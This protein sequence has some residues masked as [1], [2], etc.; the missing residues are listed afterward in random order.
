MIFHLI[1]LTK[2]GEQ[3]NNKLD[4]SNLFYDVEACISSDVGCHRQQNQDNAI[5]IQPN[6]SERNSKGFLAIVADG[7][8]GHKAG[9]IA[10]RLA[11]DVITTNF[12][13]KKQNDPLGSLQ[14]AFAKANEVIYQRS[15]TNELLSGMGTTSTALL[16]KKGYAYF[17]HVGDSRLYRIHEGRLFLLTEDH[18]VVNQMLRNGLI[19]PTEAKNHPERNVVT[20]ALGTRPVVEI[21]VSRDPCPIKIGDFFILCTDGLYDLVSDDEIREI[22]LSVAP[23]LAC[24]TLID[25]AKAKGG[26]DNISV[27]ILAIRALDTS[28]R[29]VPITRPHA[30]QAE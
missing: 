6:G 28:M 7:M 27:G 24:Q 17:A 29:P 26:Y 4:G 18:T 25:L 20:R 5:F 21:A 16:L 13:M 12:F 23:H 14:K 10:S 19:N 11:I 30:A 15:N 1:R 3:R 2:G 8:G 9:E 22:T